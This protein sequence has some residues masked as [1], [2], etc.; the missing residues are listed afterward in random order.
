MPALLL[1]TS[2]TFLGFQHLLFFLLCCIKKKALDKHYY[3]LGRR[4]S[5]P[6]T[7]GTPH[8]TKNEGIV[9]QSNSTTRAQ[10]VSLVIPRDERYDRGSTFWLNYV[11]MNHG[12][13]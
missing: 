11:L 12:A 2:P 9:Q 4:Q 8:V 6:T 1:D 7:P 13:S 5:H 10:C 3:P